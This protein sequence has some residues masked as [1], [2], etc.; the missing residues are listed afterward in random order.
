[1]KLLF[2]SFILAAVVASAAPITE[3]VKLINA[4][5]PVLI[6]NSVTVDGVTKH[7]VAIGPYTLQI[8]GQNV[9]GLCI[10][11]FDDSHINDTWSAYVTPVSGGNFTNTL[12]PTYGQEYEESAYIYSQIVNSSG[13][14]RTDWQ[15][16]AWDIMAYGITNSSYKYLIG[17]NSDID[18]ALANYNKINLTGFQ[19]LTDTVKDCDQEF[20]VATPEPGNLAL[21]GLGLL[22]TGLGLARRRRFAAQRAARA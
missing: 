5:N 20:M 11:F 14:V 10:D 6:D 12:H 1:M 13:S 2:S 16:A 15:I 4:G 9:A 7:G 8:N 17:D 22:C 18:S 21:L 3:Q 19:I